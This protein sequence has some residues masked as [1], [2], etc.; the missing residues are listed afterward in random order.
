MYFASVALISTSTKYS[1]TAIW[2]I[3]ILPSPTQRTFSD[4][5]G[6][7]PPIL[8]PEATSWRKADSGICTPRHTE[9]SPPFYLHGFSR[10]VPAVPVRR[11]DHLPGPSLSASS[12]AATTFNAE[13][14]PMYSP[15]LSNS[16]YTMAID[17]ASEICKAPVSS[18]TKVAKLFVIRP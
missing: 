10:S 1:T 12:T 14:A 6:W 3:S 11:S 9:E 5:L 4:F 15:S 18:F 2:F 8:S 7:H 13:L 16:S 17:L